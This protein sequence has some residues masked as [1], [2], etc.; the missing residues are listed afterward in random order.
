MRALLL[1]HSVD[2]LR[3]R[4]D[5]GHGTQ[6]L[7]VPRIARIVQPPPRRERQWR[8]RHSGALRGATAEAL[9][10]NCP[11][12]CLDDERRRYDVRFIMRSKFC[13]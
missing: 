3:R 8:E 9:E 12:E 1:Y 13:K 5:R 2:D 11:V 6:V 4:R 10:Q 7:G